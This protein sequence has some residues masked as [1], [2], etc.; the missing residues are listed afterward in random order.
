M[1][2]ISTSA[3]LLIII[4]SISI[5][6]IGHT[7]ANPK[8]INVPL[9]YQTISAAIGNASKGDTIFIER[10]TYSE[11]PFQIDKAVTVIGEAKENTTI[12]FHSNSFNR[13][14]DFHGRALTLTFWENMLNITA[15]DVR[16]SDLTIKCADNNGGAILLSG[17]RTELTNNKIEGSIS[18]SGNGIQVINNSFSGGIRLTGSNLTIAQNTVEELIDC[19]NGSNNIIAANIIGSGIKRTEP[20][21]YYPYFCINIGSF[22]IV[23]GNNICA[24]T[25][26]GLGLNGNGT[27]VAKNNMTTSILVNGYENIFCGNRITN[28]GLIVTGGDNVFYSNDVYGYNYTNPQYDYDLKRYTLYYPQSA[29]YALSLGTCYGAILTGHPSED[30]ANNTFRNN[31]FLGNTQIRLWTDVSEPSALSNVIEE[32]YWRNYNGTDD[33]DDGLGDSP[34]VF[35]VRNY[36]YTRLNDTGLQDAY[37]LIAPFNGTVNIQLPFWAPPFAASLVSVPDETAID[38]TL[39]SKAIY[40]ALPLGTLTFAVCAVL[41]FYIKKQRLKNSLHVS[42]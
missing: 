19:H 42:S 10:G 5:L 3:A 23:I 40:I 20:S 15:P 26:G 41:L 8:M 31:S 39:S 4:L 22:S 2:K 37:P 34:Y 11:E 32:N 18:G 36:E 13:T 6:P 27:I 38:T 12:L 1:P 17:E 21:S 9:D 28:G 33:N 29:P 24:G 14:V 7:K 25:N 35:D 30:T 16:I